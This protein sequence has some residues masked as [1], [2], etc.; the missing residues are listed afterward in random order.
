MFISSLHLLNFKDSFLLQLGS[1][2][3]SEMLN[4]AV[5]PVQGRVTSV[6][7]QQM[8][9][10]ETST[11]RKSL[12]KMFLRVSVITVQTPTFF[13]CMTYVFQFLTFLTPLFLVNL[14]ISK[15]LC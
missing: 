10:C 15:N 6:I 2:R 11:Y 13:D 4:C 5:S 9:S 8:R 14:M 7:T 12:N 1:Y 3:I